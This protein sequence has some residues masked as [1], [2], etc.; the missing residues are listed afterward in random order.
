MGHSHRAKGLGVGVDKAWITAERPAHCLPDAALQQIV[1]LGVPET[2]MPAWGD[3]LSEVQIQA[4]VGFMCSW[5]PTAPEVAQPVRVRG[6]WW[7]G[8]PVAG[9]PQ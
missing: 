9:Q 4:I 2:F 5:E 6:P 3:R 1:T 8:C 7:Q